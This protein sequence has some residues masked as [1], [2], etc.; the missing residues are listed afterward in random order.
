VTNDPIFPLLLVLARFIKAA[1]LDQI[2]LGRYRQP[3]E[4]DALARKN[5][6]M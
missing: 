6:R 1:G 2:R 5:V 4:G 3:E